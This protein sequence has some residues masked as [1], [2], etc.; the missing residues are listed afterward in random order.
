MELLAEL[1][2]EIQDNNDT[3]PLYFNKNIEILYNFIYWMK[4]G[5]AMAKQTGPV[6]TAL[7]SYCSSNQSKSI[8]ATVYKLDMDKLK[9]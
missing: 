2:T 5:L 7:H 4:N 6:P 8:T 9:G 3:V 1:D